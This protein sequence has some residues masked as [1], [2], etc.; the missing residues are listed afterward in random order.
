MA[1]GKLDLDVKE[2]GKWAMAEINFS[3]KDAADVLNNAAGDV[4]MRAISY[5][6]RASYA[7]MVKKFKIAGSQRGKMLKSGRRSR[8]KS[9]RYQT[10][11]PSRV[12]YAIINYYIKHGRMPS[13]QIG[14]MPKKL[15]GIRHAGKAAAIQFVNAKLRSIAYI[16]TGF[17]MAARFFGKKPNIRISPKGYVYHSTGVKAT[18]RSLSAEMMS[19]R[20][21][22][23]T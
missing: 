12:V 5:T 8:G 2:F 19:P 18:M 15:K 7:S 20:A 21:S 6:H 22:R 9:K 1:V 4:S 3:R 23:I 10:F 11:D 16:A 14:I 13:Y 17:A